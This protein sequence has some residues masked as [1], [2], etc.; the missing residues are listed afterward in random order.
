MIVVSDT[1]PLISLMKVSLLNVLCDLFGEIL[2]PASVYN[3]LTSNEN[4]SFEAAEIQNSA[5]IKVVTI[6]N[7]KI[8]EVLQKASGLDLGE[9]EAIAYADNVKADFLL[10]DEVRGRRVARSMGL[11]I[12]G[13]VG[14]LLA[15]Y[16]DGILSKKD[17]EDALDGLK[18]ANRRIGDDVIAAAKR[19]LA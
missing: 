16:N 5:F 17:V 11:K 3:E 14:V 2:I 1:T 15:A 10:M 19:R 4:F 12:M 7:Q 9:S 6:E 8:V 18:R 13:T